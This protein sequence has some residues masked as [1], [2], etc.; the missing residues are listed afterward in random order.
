MEQGQGRGGC[1]NWC[2]WGGLAAMEVTFEQGSDCCEGAHHCNNWGK[3]CWVTT[4]ASVKALMWECARM[5][6]KSYK[7]DGVRHSDGDLYGNE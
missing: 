3:V 7:A 1:F 4:T 5:F 2:V 6:R